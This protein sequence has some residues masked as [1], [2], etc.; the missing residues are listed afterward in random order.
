MR[1]TGAFLVV[2]IAFATP[3]QAQGVE[4]PESAETQDEQVRRLASEGAAL[5][6]DEAY[7]AAFEKLDA[8]YRLQRVPTL[9][10]FS[11]SCLEKMG[12]WVEAADRYLEATRLPL[13]DEKREV[14]E[15]AQG[16]AA[17]LRRLLLPRLPSLLLTVNGDPSPIV[18]LDGEPLA[19]ARLGTRVAV[20]PGLHHIE[21]KASDGRV[22]K[23]ELT[24][25][26]GKVNTVEITFEAP[27]APEPSPPAPDPVPPTPA[28][29]VDPPADEGTHAFVVAG[30]ASLGL[31]AAGLVVGG[32]AGGVL[33]GLDGELAEACFEDRC[34]PERESDVARFNTLRAVTTAGFVVGGVGLAT[35]LTLL[36]LAPH[37]GESEAAVMPWVGPTSVGLRGRF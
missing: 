32:V 20:D 5:Y 34:L 25:V 11:A 31:G 28:K 6:R 19:S 36:L 30:W 23:R 27:Q 2:V 10:R 33:L 37:D 14:H 15:E 3:A 9:A 18:T 13:P 35:G 29:P 16:D 24:A 12:R 8:A 1:A 4:P 22:E 26:E 17:E 7:A 21:V